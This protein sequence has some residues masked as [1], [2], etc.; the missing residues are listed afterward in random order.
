MRHQLSQ[1]TAVTLTFLA[2]GLFAALPEIGT[3]G[4]ALARSRPQFGGAIAQRRI[5]FV[6][7]RG[8]DSPAAGNSAWNPFGSISYA[9]QYA[10]SGTVIQLAPGR[11]DRENFPLKLPRGVVLQGE[12]TRRGEGFEII[13]GGDYP[14]RFF[15]R[16]NA[17]IV[18][19]DNSQ[20]LGVTVINPGVRGTGIWIED[21]NSTVRNSTLINNNR[22]GIAIVGSANPLIESN[23]FEENR[24]NGLFIGNQARG[25]IRNNVFRRTGY[26]IA[27]AH[28]ATPRI[29]RN[30]IFNN[31]SGIVI[32]HSARPQ[33][34][35]NRIEDNFQYAIVAVDKARPIVDD[36]T[37]IGNGN[38]NEFLAGVPQDRPPTP[39]QAGVLVQQPFPNTR[40]SCMRSGGGFATVVRQG[41]NT[42]P[43]IFMRWTRQVDQFSP[44]SICQIIT[45]R[46]NDL[47]AE[48]G[49]NFNGLRLAIDGGSNEELT[50]EPC[51]VRE[52]Q[53]DCN[54]Q[55]LIFTTDIENATI[56]NQL[57][58]ASGDGIYQLDLTNASAN[59]DVSDGSEGATY[60]NLQNLD[61]PWESDPGLWFMDY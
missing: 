40:F 47:V 44:E 13:G 38:N 41:A 48:N 42:I 49:G 9:L 57:V 33:V 43:K 22:D 32:T 28:E 55:T 60:I 36:N 18:A 30:S 14:S 11:Y 34:I 26:G 54:N 58:M 39:P 12:E 29:V 17:T 5:L 35:G 8:T 61:R 10:T 53:S 59:R 16:Q 20:I 4:V 51:W 25:E 15:G 6:D 46:L 45:Q 24:G 56:T 23:R 52:G 19:G 50:R 37:L 7:P 2:S 21:I 31:R 27:V 3:E 1:V